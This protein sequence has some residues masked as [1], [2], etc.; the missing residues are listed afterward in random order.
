MAGLIRAPSA[1][2]PWS[3]EEGALAR[4]KVVLARMR[5]EGFISAEAEEKA[6]A[7][8]VRMTSAP[9]LA[10]AHSGYAKE[11]LR[12]AFREQVGDDDPPDWEVQTTFLPAVQLAAERAVE[13]G[14][15][16][17]GKR[18]LQA[19]LVA[20]DPETGDILAMVGGRNFNA[21][22]FNRAVRSR[23]QPG[24]AFK[25]FVYAAALDRGFSPVTVLDGL[26]SVTA[27]GT[28]GVEPA[29]R[30]GGHA[31]RGDPARSAAGVEQPGGGGLAAP[32]RQRAPCWPWPPTSACATSPT[33]PRS[34]WAPGWSPRSS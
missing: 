3:N 10:D 8:R 2:S 33:S 32:H 15:A 23:R 4:S 28:A 16:R 11:Y 7:A 12:Q 27:P 22:P 14:L 18:G 29:Q 24:S 19:A 9:R 17:L 31:G 1:L 30:G 5:Q 6:N 34:P 26:H 21:S 20:L 13:E 25:P